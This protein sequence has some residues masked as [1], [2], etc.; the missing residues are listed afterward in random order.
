[1]LGFRASYDS[2]P[3]AGELAPV[4]IAFPDGSSIHAADPDASARLSE[5]LGRPVRL[6]RAKADERS[7]GEIDP[8]TIFADVPVEQLLPNFTSQTLPDTF[9]LMRGAFFD[10]APIHVLAS[11]SLEHHEAAVRRRF[12]TRP[13]PLSSQHFRRHRRHRR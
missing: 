11:A 9:G 1:M 4:T 13:A 6:E 2:T 5:V 8:Q 7:R 3:R 10:S 12:D